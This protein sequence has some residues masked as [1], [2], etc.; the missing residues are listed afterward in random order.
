M[1]IKELS[2]LI[3]VSRGTIDRVLH[4]RGRVSENTKQI[5]LKA[6]KEYGYVPNHMGKALA[7]IKKSHKIGVLSF[8]G[9]D[10]FYRSIIDGIKD[11][12]E[13][14][15]DC[16]FQML[17]EVIREETPELIKEKLIQLHE[18]GAD[19]IIFSA[20]GSPLICDTVQYLEQQGVLIVT[21]NAEL[22]DN[23]RI[24]HVGHNNIQSGQTAARMISGLIGNTGKVLIVAGSRDFESHSHRLEGVLS[25]FSERMPQIEIANIVEYSDSPEV[26][27]NEIIR[28]LKAY[29]VDAV[30]VLS[31]YSEKAI[32]AI[33]F[34]GLSDNVLVG[35][36]DLNENNIEYLQKEKISFVIDQL[37]YSQGYIAM[38][39][40]GN[41]LIS[42]KKPE[43]ENYYTETIIIIKENLPDHIEPER[44][45]FNYTSF[46]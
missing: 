21:V 42:N 46:Y 8:K 43:R 22:G 17:E 38:N 15:K 10:Y 32:K 28:S 24:C 19:A 30:L 1:T 29:P 6:L 13:K 18:Q 35:V 34:L 26:V 25:F 40:V 5:V 27:Y 2:S 23:N 31:I 20:L 37:P 3:N 44:L 4:N 45:R 7:V 33:E 14:F 11:S 9:K 41:Y 12:F 36:F 39:I 16:K